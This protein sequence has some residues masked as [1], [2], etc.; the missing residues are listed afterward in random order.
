M[1]GWLIGLLVALL[2]I[3]PLFFL[4]VRWPI[5]IAQ[6]RGITGNTLTKVTVPS[7]LGSFFE[8][9]DSLQ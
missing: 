8:L 7:W 2:I 6:D 1:A 5:R 9:P 3:I 4:L